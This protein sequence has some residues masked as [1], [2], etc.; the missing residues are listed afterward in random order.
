MHFRAD[1]DLIVKNYA[2]NQ[3]YPYFRITT[4]I[5]KNLQ[6]QM[7]TIYLFLHHE[8]YRSLLATRDSW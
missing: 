1:L 8:S 4:S 7:V 2:I 3:K 5:K 6:P